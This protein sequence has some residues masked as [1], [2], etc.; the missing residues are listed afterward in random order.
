M[1]DVDGSASHPESRRN[2]S[3]NLDDAELLDDVFSRYAPVPCSNHQRIS[4][5]A[6]LRCDG[7]AFMGAAARDIRS[8]N[9]VPNLKELD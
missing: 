8:N 3:Q 9:A 1:D 2:P 4:D 7:L 6:E 5:P